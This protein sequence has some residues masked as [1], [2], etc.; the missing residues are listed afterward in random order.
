VGFTPLIDSPLFSGLVIAVVTSRI[1]T[2][3]DRAGFPNR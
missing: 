3:N 2:I 1:G